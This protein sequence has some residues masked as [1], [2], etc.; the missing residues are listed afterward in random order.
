[1]WPD[2]IDLLIAFVLSA[3]LICTGRLAEKLWPA[4]PNQ[5][6]E[7]FNFDLKYGFVNLSAS[8][9]FTPFA[10]VAS[11][12]IINRAGGGFIHLPATGWWFALSLA[13]YLLTKDMLE[14]F[15]HRAQHRFPILWSMHSLHHSEE[16]VNVS[17]AWRHYW[18]ESVLRVA[19]VFPIIGIIFE[20]PPLALDIGAVLY[21]LNHIWAHLN[22]RHSMGRWTL[23]MMNPQYHRLHHS[24]QPEHWNRNF[25]DLFPVFDVVF[26]TAAVPKPGEFP[27]TGLVP[28]DRPTRVIDAILWPLHYAGLARAA[29]GPQGARHT[30]GVVKMP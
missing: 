28:H 5:P 27:A 7:E 13:V 3:L 15:W 24:V 2:L 1:M 14:Y 30:A 26:G 19:F 18:L 4:E 17:T 10:G 22:I 20:V 25:A 6:R 21:T 12:Y 23:W 11:I 8:W 29:N 9:L 16:A